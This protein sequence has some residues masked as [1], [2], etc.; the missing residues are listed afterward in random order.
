[1][2]PKSKEAVVASVCELIAR[3]DRE[4]ASSILASE[5]PFA[6]VE[7]AERRYS[8]TEALRVFRR[9]GFVDRYSGERLVFPGTLRLL[10]VLLPE[11][12]PFHPNW[13]VSH[14]HP[15]FWL[16]SPTIDHVVPIT[17]GGRDEEA[18][19]VSTSQLRNSAKGNWFLEE[20]GWKL[21]P[22]G[23]LRAW[24]GLC[25]WFTER[26]EAEPSLLQHAPLKRWHLALR[27]AA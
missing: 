27:R 8:E 25:A 4:G 23:N 12:F 26:I 7:S 21:V 2:T 14:T 13:K 3:G 10:S 9:D 16:L 19:W 15:A 5:F 17:R 20:L 1:M 24:D 6:P 22:P 18:N 11:S